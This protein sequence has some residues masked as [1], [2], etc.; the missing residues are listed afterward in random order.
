MERPVHKAQPVLTEQMEQL[1]HKV[2]LVLQ[3]QMASIVGIQI[4]TE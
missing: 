3:E 2:Q 1:A 4:T